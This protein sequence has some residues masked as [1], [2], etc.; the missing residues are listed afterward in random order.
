[1]VILLIIIVAIILMDISSYFIGACYIN[2][3]WLL[4]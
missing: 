1:M 4:L 3:Y 2:G